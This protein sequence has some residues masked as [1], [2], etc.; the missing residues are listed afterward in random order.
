M[1]ALETP[2]NKTGKQARPGQR[3]LH[4]VHPQEEHDLVEQQLH[5]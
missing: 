2:T 1:L 4:L 5:L 3:T